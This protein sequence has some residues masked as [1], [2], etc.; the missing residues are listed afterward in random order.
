MAIKRKRGHFNPSKAAEIEFNR[1]LRGV[2]KVSS[3]IVELHMG[4]IDT[5]HGVAAMQAALKTYSDA[6][7]PW[8]RRQAAKMLEKVSKANKKGY[9]RKSKLIGKLVQTNIA[10]QEVGAVAVALMTEQ[11]ALIKSIPLRAGKRAQKLAQEAY[12]K[13]TRA[14]QLAE[15]IRKTTSVSESTATLI[16]RTEVAR[17][18]ASFTQARAQAVGAP[19]YIWRT[20]MDG[21]E[22]DS[23][24]KMNGKYVEY[25]KEPHLIDGTTGHAGTFPNCRCYQDVQFA[26]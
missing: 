20:T 3:H 8:A 6:I 18:N 14:D 23:H 17:A 7:D 10:D 13:G 4:G 25:S 15:E 12:L 2:A 9:K 16:A 21:A 22:R 26:V 24:A 11:V 19:G 1:A 5:A